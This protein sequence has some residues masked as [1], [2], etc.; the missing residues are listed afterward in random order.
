MVIFIMWCSYLLHG[1]MSTYLC[2]IS[3]LI[4]EIVFLQTEE[5]INTQDKIL[6]EG[7]NEVNLGCMTFSYIHRGK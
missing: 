5:V 7:D 6:L 3:Y 2:L 1:F 4:L